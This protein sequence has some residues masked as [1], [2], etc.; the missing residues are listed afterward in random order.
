MRVGIGGSLSG[1]YQGLFSYGP[2][3]ALSASPPTF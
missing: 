1:P 3:V 2:K